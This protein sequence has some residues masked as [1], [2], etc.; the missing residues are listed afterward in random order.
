[1]NFGLRIHVFVVGLFD[2]HVPIILVV[3]KLSIRAVC[4]RCCVFIGW[5]ACS[6]MHIFVITD[7]L[8]AVCRCCCVLIGWLSVYGCMFLWLLAI[9]VILTSLITISD[10]QSSYR[11][12][13]TGHYALSIFDH[14][15]TTCHTCASA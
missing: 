3:N 14:G 5:G 2:G 4:R 12:Q 15:G 13:Q 7:D 1:M 8:G 6:W 10:I 9:L 11:H